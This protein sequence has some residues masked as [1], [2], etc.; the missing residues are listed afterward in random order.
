MRTG[1]GGVKAGSQRSLTE[2]LTRFSTVPVL[3]ELTLP[4]V[5]WGFHEFWASGPPK[6]SSYLSKFIENFYSLILRHLA[7]AKCRFSSSYIEYRNS[8]L[9]PA[10]RG[11]GD[12]GKNTL[13]QNV[14]KE[15]NDDFV[16]TISQEHIGYLSKRERSSLEP[17]ILRVLFIN[18]ENHVHDRCASHV[19]SP[20]HVQTDSAMSSS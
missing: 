20:L 8:S 6:I 4:S 10:R 1:S 7:D 13:F 12:A 18:I 17:V 2:G 19:K 9:H 16:V 5:C 11:G 14:R 15:V 3:T